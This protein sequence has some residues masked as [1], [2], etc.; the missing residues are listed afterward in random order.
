MPPL[1]SSFNGTSM[2]PAA[3]VFSSHSFTEA[4]RM[5]SNCWMYTPE[6]DLRAV[7]MHGNGSS[8]AV[9]GQRL[10]RRMILD[11]GVPRTIVAYLYCPDKPSA[12]LR[13]EVARLAQARFTV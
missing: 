7:T 6:R 3:V 10:Q 8:V 9:D 4:R 1:R 11:D 13:S 5:L 2:E 12:E